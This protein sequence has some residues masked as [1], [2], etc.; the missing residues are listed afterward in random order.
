MKTISIFAFL[1]AVLIGTASAQKLGILEKS[2]VEKAAKGNLAEVEL[3]K[4]AQ[5]KSSDSQVK[6]FGQQMVTDHSKANDELKPIA[7]SA[8]VKW[9]DQLTGESK[10]LYDR[11]QKLSGNKFDR[12]Y[13]RSMVE[14]HK[15]DVR[16]YKT[17]SKLVKDPQLKTYVD[18][19]LP[20]IEQHLTH[21]ESVNKTATSSA[22]ST[23]SL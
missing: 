2:F 22:A 15:K 10:E 6:D 20:V 16:E 18:Q 14:D 8:K 5:E 11:L 7:D 3:G 23:K 9:P 4:L 21:A 17:Q 19:T 12:L 13:I 1:A